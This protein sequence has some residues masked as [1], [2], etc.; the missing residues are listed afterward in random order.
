MQGFPNEEIGTPHIT[1]VELP[2]MSV[3]RTLNSACKVMHVN[4][5]SRT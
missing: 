2:E 1:D 4:H 3:K 5:T